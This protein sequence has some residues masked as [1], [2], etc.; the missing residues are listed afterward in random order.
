[1]STTE[2]QLVF[3]GRAVQR[4][5]IDAQLFATSLAGYSQIF[6]RAN[7]IVNGEA[8]EAIVLVESDFKA[9]S[10][11]VSLQFQQEILEAAK[12]LITDHQFLTAGSLAALIGFVKKGGEW[13]DSLID[14]WKL[15]RGKKPDKVTKTGNNTE[16]T[17]GDN[18]KT[19]SNVVYNLYGDS[20]IRA[21][22][23][24]ATEPLRRDGFNRIAVKQ[25]NSEQ[26]AINKEEAEYFESELLALES[27]ETPREGERD[28][29]L[30]VSKIAFSERS[31]WSFFEQ[32]G[33]VVAKIEDEEFWQ[34]VHDHVIKFGEGDRLKV[35]MHWEVEERNG[36]LRQRNRIIRVYQV[37]DRPKQ[38]RLDGR[39]EDD[40][41]RPPRRIR[42]IRLDDE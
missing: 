23:G 42:S 2:I 24:Q 18:R 22:F 31:T 1:M 3:E 13:G 32:G 19:V 12:R 14:L 27:D 36:K 21:A 8:S 6:H 15:L 35:R 40:E 16:I 9:G 4:G 39:R 26:V 34:K 7:A 11:I 20:A 25:N 33:T 17:F 30:I 38:M 29:V 5:M 28:A 41:T 37:F 10:F